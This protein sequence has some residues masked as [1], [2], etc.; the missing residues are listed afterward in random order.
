MIHTLDDFVEPLVHAPPSFLLA[1]VDFHH[2][3]IHPLFKS[4]NS[5]GHDAPHHG[6]NSALGIDVGCRGWARSR[7]RSRRLVVGGGIGIGIGVVVGGWVRT[8]DVGVDVEATW[9]LASWGWGTLGDPLLVVVVAVICMVYRRA[10]W[11]L[12]F[13]MV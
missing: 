6:L 10:T 7:R 9:S 5:F 12:A 4:L 13:Y 11:G 3:S 1:S 2:S 8:V